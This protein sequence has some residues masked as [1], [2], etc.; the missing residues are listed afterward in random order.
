MEDSFNLDDFAQES[1]NIHGNKDCVRQNPV[2][3]E[4]KKEE[5]LKFNQ[6]M[7][8]SGDKFFPASSTVKQLKSGMYSFDTCMNG[9][10]LKSEPINTDGLVEFPDS[11]SNEVLK[12]IEIFWDSYGEYKKYDFLHRRGMLFYGNPG[13][14]KSCLVQQIIKKIIDRNGIVCLCNGNLKVFNEGIK[15]LRMIE[16][17]RN[18]VCIFEDIDAIIEHQGDDMLLAMLDGENQIDRVLNIATTNYPQ[19]LD[20]RIVAR[21]RRFDE[22]VLIGM[23]PESVRRLYFKKKIM[24]LGKEVDEKE[25]EKYVH[26]TKDF[27]FAGMA[28]LVISTKCFKKPLEKS[29]ETLRKLLNNKES[30]FDESS[31]M[32]F[33]KK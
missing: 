2:L 19:K 23:P 11:V 22:V 17:Q 13:S 18:I 20:K 8:Q 28:E 16:P 6:W 21:P 32:G 1:N 25:L 9:L 29:V 10:F 3:A 4:E 33:G 26:L 27:S 30:S 12:Q 5:N 15:L 31:P 7:E 14:G 24:E